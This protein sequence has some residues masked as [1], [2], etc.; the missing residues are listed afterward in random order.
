MELGPQ[1]TFLAFSGAC[2]PPG[3]HCL[4]RVNMNE[5]GTAVSAAGRRIT[6]GNPSEGA[7]AV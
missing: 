1:A 6:K 2:V 5:R 3:E 7:A 4:A